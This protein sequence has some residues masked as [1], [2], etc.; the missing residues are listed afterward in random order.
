MPRLV[1]LCG[2]L[3][4]CSGAGNELQTP[5]AGLPDG[6]T[7]DGGV[8]FVLSWPPQSASL[9]RPRLLGA[10]ADLS[11]LRPKLTK[12]PHR[13]WMQRMAQRV[14][15]GRAQEPDDHLRGAERMKANAARALAAFY[16]LDWTVIEGEP[17]PFPSP[18]DRQAAAAE[19]TEML[20]AMYTESRIAVPP[21]LGGWDRD[22]TTS[23]EI[24]LWASAYDALLGAGYEMDP[25]DEAQIRQNLI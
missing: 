24:I 1:L 8:P 5:D 23:E 13:S 15:D 20:K 16:M 21:P 19:A 3:A 22:I 7:P 25:R 12:E 10:G 17:T 14:S 2:L 4:A 11:A 6:G 18:E 9:E